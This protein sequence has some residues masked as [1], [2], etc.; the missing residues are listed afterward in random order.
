MGLLEEERCCG[1]GCFEDLRVSNSPEARTQKEHFGDEAEPH[2]D[3]G[4][5]GLFS[6]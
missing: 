6:G 3:F 5:Q 2:E 1:P 4:L